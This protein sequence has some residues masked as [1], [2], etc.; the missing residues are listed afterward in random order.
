M[1]AIITVHG[2]GV[3]VCFA[4][5]LLVGMAK[6]SVQQKILLVG[7]ICTFLDMTGYFLELQSVSEEAARLSI[8]V[9]YIGTTMGLLSF[10]Y[11]SCLYSTHLGDWHVRL[12][13][14]FYAV[15]H[16]FILVVV[17]TIDSNTI[18]YRKVERVVRNGYYLWSID[19]G[20]VY[21]WWFIT[22]MV[23]GF[24]ITFIVLQSA[25][26][27]R[28]E[29]RPELFLLCLASLLPICLWFLRMAGVFGYYDPYPMSMMITECFLVF[30]MYKYR[31]FDTVKT[32]KDRV[33]DNIR[34]GILVTDHNGEVIYLNREISRIFPEVDWKNR[35]MVEER[36]FRFLEDHRDGFMTLKNQYYQWKSGEILDDN[37]RRAGVLY[38]ISDITEGHL[39]TRQLISL[40]EEA[41][42]ANAAKSIFLAHMSHEIR[43]PINAVLGMNEMI[44]RESCSDTIKDYARNIQNAGKIL[45]SIIN[46]ILDLSKIE[47]GQMEIVEKD[48]HLGKMLIDIE[49]MVTMRAEENSLALHI[50]ANPMLPEALHGDEQRIKQCIINFLTNSLK[51]TR[52]GQVTL[53]VDF[54][55]KDKD[56]IDL[57]ITVTDTGIGIEED[58]LAILFEPFVRLDRSKNEHIEGTGLGLSITK[59]L[60][61]RMEGRLSVESV[62]GRGS[63]FSF[64]LPQKVAGPDLLGDYK[65]KLRRVAER[66]SARE[67]FTAPGARILAVDDNRVNI[68]VARG[69]LRRLK[70]QFDSAT[71]GQE[72]LDKFAKNDY[73]IILLDHMMPVMDGVQTLHRMQETERFRQNAPA[74]IAMTANAV[75]GAREKYLEEGFTDYL[76]KPIDHKSLEEM[77]RVY[78]PEEMIRYNE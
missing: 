41:E 20:P 35:R 58:K 77:I 46:D 60:I 26:E 5:I 54:T 28:G 17:F 57:R 43:T 72:C 9:E 56:T 44:L 16:L 10:L 33:I 27:H 36:V 61:D 2:M 32:A 3:L 68:T 64:T 73:D 71:S 40:K 39:Y 69:L 24:L 29:K 1:G 8:K 12:I 49:N 30:I 53:Q 38:R 50:Q 75:I 51:Y 62:Y 63:V 66:K 67:E 34:E 45:L 6:P 52:E 37:R 25:L 70:V 65:E 22:T 55:D 11:F 31:L 18:F 14:R 4:M 7:T 48:Y 74:V 78:L 23:L 42:R 21:Y 15:N 19:P 59:K 47:S 76:S 13:K